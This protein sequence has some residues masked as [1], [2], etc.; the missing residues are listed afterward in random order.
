[1]A[2]GILH[3]PTTTLNQLN[4]IVSIILTSCSIPNDLSKERVAVGIVYITTELYMLTDTSIDYEDTWRFLKE[5]MNQL[6]HF[7][8]VGFVPSGESLVLMSAVVSS[9]GGAI[10]SLVS[11]G[12]FKNVGYGGMLSFIMSFA[13]QTSAANS[14]TNTTS[15]LKYYNE[16]YGDLKDVDTKK[17][18]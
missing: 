11:N 3:N 5:Q 9:I 13:Q 7:K 2:N 17:K 18:K 12:L 14:Q 8:N 15:D 10:V 16:K 1:M 4:D 6:D